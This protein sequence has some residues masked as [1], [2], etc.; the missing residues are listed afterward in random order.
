MSS[1]P[2]TFG[3]DPTRLYRSGDEQMRQIASVGQLSQW[4]FH[5]CGLPFITIGG[6][7]YY[8]GVDVIRHLTE[9]R[10]EPRAPAAA[11]AGAPAAPA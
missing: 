10:V 6:N 4:R 1:A 8:A 2:L 9:Q 11:T 7:V 5:K 3:F